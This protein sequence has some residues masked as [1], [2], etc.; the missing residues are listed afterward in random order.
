M[1]FSCKCLINF[2]DQCSVLISSGVASDQSCKE[3][4]L[5]YGAC[6]ALPP[7][8]AVRTAESVYFVCVCVIVDGTQTLTWLK[9]NVT[10]QINGQKYL[11]FL[12]FYCY[13][14]V[15]PPGATTHIR[16]QFLY[17]CVCT[18]LIHKSTCTDQVFSVLPPAFSNLIIPR[19]FN[20][21]LY[22]SNC[23]CGSLSVRLQVSRFLLSSQYKG[24][25][26]YRDRLDYTK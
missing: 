26:E 22:K 1:Q 2:M 12:F 13:F 17:Y 14:F 20:Y 9:K 23:H 18:S 6:T 11:A 7:Q 16:T 4:A 25:F 21:F 19:P 24:F 10:Q 5:S 15:L 3:K 8:I